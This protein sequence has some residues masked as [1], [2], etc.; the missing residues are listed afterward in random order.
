MPDPHPQAPAV[1][2]LGDG[3]YAAFDGF[4]I[5]L[6]VNHHQNPVACYLEPD[7]LAALIRFR[8]RHACDG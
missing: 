7:V 4:G 3:V 5:A 6:R 2:H 1:E 8:D